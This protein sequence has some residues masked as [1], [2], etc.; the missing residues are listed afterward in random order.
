MNSETERQ[1]VLFLWLEDSNLEGRVVAWTFHDGAGREQ[2]IAGTP[3]GKE[4][5]EQA[6]KAARSGLDVTR[7]LANGRK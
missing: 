6:R 2:D 3:L 1:Q 5:P 7:E 4:S